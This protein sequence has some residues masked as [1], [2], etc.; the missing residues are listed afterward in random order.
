MLVLRRPNLVLELC[1]LLHTQIVED[2]KTEDLSVKSPPI[3]SGSA[4]APATTDVP[5][6]AEEPPSSPTDRQEQRFGVQKPTSEAQA[7]LPQWPSHD[8]APN[9]ALH[10]AN[11]ICQKHLVPGGSRWPGRSVLPA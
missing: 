4:D 8:P 2:V 11:H 1:V 10:S 3:A 7:E 6:M 9:H 5:T